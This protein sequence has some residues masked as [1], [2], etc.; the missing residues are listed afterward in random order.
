MAERLPL[1]ATASRGTEPLVA[2]ELETLGAKKVRQGR[3][4]VSFMANL[5]EAMRL[6][7]H[8]RLAM[9]VLYPLGEFESSGQEGLYDAASSVPWE[10]WLTTTST[11][12]VDA[13]LTNSEHT[14]SGFVALKIKDGIVDRMRKTKGAR[15]DVD[16]H[17]PDV[18]IV[19]HLNKNKLSLSLDLCGDSLF[20][21]GYRIK[22]TPAPLKET[23]AAAVLMA[24]GYDGSEPLADPMCGS[25]TIVIEAG[26]IATNRPPGLKRHFAVERWP[27]LG[28]KATAL[29]EEV[30]LE[31]TAKLRPA[32]HPILARD[33]DEEA[34]EAV[35]RNVVAAGLSTVVRIEQADAIH[36]EP[37]ADISPGLICTNPP[38][39]D[40]LSAGGQKGMKTF[41][42]Q[43]GEGMNHWAGWR[44]AFLSG[45]SA[46]ESAFHHRPIKRTPMFNGPIECTLTEYGPQPVKNPSPAGAE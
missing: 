15:P 29:L 27:S 11:F 3:G 23:L 31:A 6:I 36:T 34:I 39:G 24:S 32:P 21:R 22:T 4:G 9:R 10:D 41:Y 38:Y 14:H 18:Q 28:E 2:A 5:D 30:K 16:T 8:S 17:S 46:F 33:R 45:N 20:K 42:F 35:K 7:V 13:T 12:A 44:M 1:F 19:A 25:G 26:Y 37:P 43:L 40:R